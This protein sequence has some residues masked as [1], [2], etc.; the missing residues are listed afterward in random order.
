MSQSDSDC[1][2][3]RENGRE[4]FDPRHAAFAEAHAIG[5]PIGELAERFSV[6]PRTCFRWLEREDVRAIV[7][8]MRDVSMSC[9]VGR[10]VD[11][12]L[13]AIN[14]LA[15]LMANPKPSIALNAARTL[16]DLVIRLRTI[17]EYSARLAKLEEMLN[18]SG[19]A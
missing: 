14:K 17:E 7:R 13:A 1:H 6:S 10:S 19:G 3:S 15:E 9:V 8:E 11:C 12:T 2:E 4:S 16:A 18:H 5:V